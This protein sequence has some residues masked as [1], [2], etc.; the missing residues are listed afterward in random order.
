MSFSLELCLKHVPWKNHLF[1][2]HFDNLILGWLV[3][4]M[5]CNAMQC[6]PNWPLALHNCMSWL[7]SLCHYKSWP[8]WC[9]YFNTEYICCI[10]YIWSN[11]L[12]YLYKVY[13]YTDQPSFENFIQRTK[14][15]GSFVQCK[16]AKQLII[17]T[18]YSCAGGTRSA[19][20][21]ALWSFS[22]RISPPKGP[23]QICQAA[24]D[25]T[26]HCLQLS[27]IILSCSSAICIIAVEKPLGL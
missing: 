5:Q 9:K 12:Q 19:L 1:N 14:S 17:C 4:T 23:V 11:V 26:L 27:C 15:G 22:P 3:G 8:N 25:L 21:S 20:C 2:L 7:A 16:H 6:E 10:C 18:A 24:H 13:L